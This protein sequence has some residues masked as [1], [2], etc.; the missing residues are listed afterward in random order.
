MMIIVHD[1][2]PD[3]HFTTSSAT[4]GYSFQ[5]RCSFISLFEGLIRT[6][7]V[8]VSLEKKLLS[9]NNLK[10]TNVLYGLVCF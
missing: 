1:P 7:N 5:H 2:L 6:I 4:L 8:H 10:E 9:A 3:G